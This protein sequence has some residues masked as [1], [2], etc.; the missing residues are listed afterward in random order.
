[1]TKHGIEQLFPEQ[2][3]A[4]ASPGKFY[5]RPPGGESWCDVILRLRSA[6]DTLALHHAGQRVMIICHQVTVLCLRY[7]LENL[8]EAQ[9]L[10]IDAQGEVANASS[11]E[12]VASPEVSRP[13]LVRYNAVEPMLRTGTPITAQPEDH[14]AKPWRNPLIQPCSGPCRCQTFRVRETRTRAAVFLSLRVVR[15]C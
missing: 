9:I 10:D 14:S 13:E 12:Y 7:L 11:Q 3:A 6:L 15:A 1:L 8:T 5:H 4:R 2:F